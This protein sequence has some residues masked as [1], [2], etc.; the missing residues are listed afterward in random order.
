[1]L[2]TADDF[3]ANPH[4]LFTNPDV[5]EEMKRHFRRLGWAEPYNRVECLEI[6]DE[7][8]HCGE[9]LKTPYIYWQGW[10]GGISLHPRCAMRMGSGWCKRCIR[11]R[12]ANVPNPSV[13][14]QLGWISSPRRTSMSWRTRNYPLFDAKVKPRHADGVVKQSAACRRSGTWAQG[15]PAEGTA[16]SR[17]ENGRRRTSLMVFLRG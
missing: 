6:V 15:C 12:R 16:F 8:F 13:T 3:A 10:A 9:K 4:D 5:P 2:V 7:C 17:Q 11:S 1:M 14:R